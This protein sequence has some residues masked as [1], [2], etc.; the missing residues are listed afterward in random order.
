MH[1]FDAATAE[2]RRKRN[3]KK[4]GSALMQMETTWKSVY[5]T[6]VIESEEWTAIKQQPITVMVEDSSPLKGESPLPKKVVF[7]FQAEDGIRDY[8]VTGVQTCALP[9]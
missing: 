6:E 9:I 1:L 8:K 7:F 4:D 3:Q 5:Q 2:M